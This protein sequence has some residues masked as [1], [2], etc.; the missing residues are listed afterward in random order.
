MA[1]D[2]RSYDGIA[3]RYDQVWAPRFEVV[4]KRIW[5]LIPPRPGD[6]ILDIGTGT[7]VLPRTIPVVDRR[8]FIVVGCDLSPVMVRRAGTRVAGL[9]V[10]VADGTKLPFCTESFDLATASFVLSH[11]RQYRAALEEAWRVLKPSGMLAVSNWAPASDPYGPAW[12]ECLAGAVS[13]EEVQ[14]AGAEVAPWEDHFSDPAVLEAAVRQAGFTTRADVV[15]VE[16]HLTVEEF[17][18]D[19]ELSSSGRRGLQL[20]G[21]ARWRRFKA[22]AAE[23]FHARFGSSFTYRRHAVIVIGGKPSGELPRQKVDDT[24]EGIESKGRRDR[25]PEV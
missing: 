9:H 15:A 20:L 14:R 6:K 4:A 8:A 7:G 12:T 16:S 5:A 21:T 2:W 10:V 11:A 3:D 17:L 13:K 25:R 18:D 23:M 1:S 24:L 19:R 22:S